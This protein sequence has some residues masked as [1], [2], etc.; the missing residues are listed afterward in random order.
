MSRVQA[1]DANQQRHQVGQ[2]KR[3]AHVLAHARRQAGLAVAG[4]GVGGHGHDGQVRQPQLF[5]DDSGRTIAVQHGHLQV[6]QHRIKLRR[7]RGH[8]LH[9]ELAIGRHGDNRAFGGEQFLGHLLVDQVVF[10][11]QKTHAVEPA[12]AAAPAG[13]LAQATLT[14]RS[15]HHRIKHHGAGDRLDQKAVQ[16]V[17]LLRRALGQGFAPVGGDH[18]HHR[19]R[20]G[21]GGAE[22]TQ[23]PGGLPAVHLGHLPVDANHRIGKGRTGRQG[24]GAHP[25][26]GLGTAVHPLHRPAPGAD[27]A[28]HQLTGNGVVVHHQHALR[29]QWGAGRRGQLGRHK[30]RARQRHREGKRA[31][32]PQ[33]AGDADTPAH[34]RHQTLTNGQAQA[35]A[36]KAPGGGRL[37]LREAAED[38]AQ[39]FRRNADPRVLHRKLDGRMGLGQPGVAQRNHHLPLRRELDGVAPQVDEH[40]LQPHGVA[41]QHIGQGGVNIKQHFQVFAAHVGRQHHREVA[42]QAVQSK[43]HALQRHLAGLDF[44]EIQNVIEQTQQRLGRPLGF[45]GVVLLACRQL[46]VLQQAEQ[47]Q[48]GVHGGA[49]FVAHVGQKLPLALAGLFG[50]FAGVLERLGVV[51]GFGDINVG[52]HNARGLPLTVQADAAIAL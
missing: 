45:A 39:V 49:D 25:R 29:R 43:R 42:Q 20:S 2:I 5:A 8:G 18:D 23:A 3:L 35:G 11:H 48:N 52:A 21:A 40:L 9:A 7:R 28:L 41:Q 33:G 1:G 37:G 30:L 51:S 44:G 17:L 47:A 27:R 24:L 50:L 46:G 19:L 31:A 38:M 13:R 36:T 12:L 10:H 34:Q 4:H 14:G 22:F 32:L 16:H 15:V 26:Q 6:H